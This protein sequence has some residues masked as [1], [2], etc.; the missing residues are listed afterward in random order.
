MHQSAPLP[1]PKLLPG[2]EQQRTGVVEQVFLDPALGKSDAVCVV[3]SLR[4]T[5][6]VLCFRALSLLFRF[7]GDGF[8][9][10]GQNPVLVRSLVEAG[11]EIQFVGELRQTLE[12]VYLQLVRNSEDN[13]PNPA[14][15]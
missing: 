7:G 9:P 15:N 2:A 6:S 4:G 10:L 11:A 8:G 1:A 14:R 13:E 3:L 5:E 12:D